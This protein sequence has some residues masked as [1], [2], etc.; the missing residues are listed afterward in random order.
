MSLAFKRWD[1][2]MDRKKK[3]RL[4]QIF[5]LVIGLGIVSITYL[6]KNGL[7]ESNIISSDLKNKIDNNAQNNTG[8]NAN[9]FYNVK[10]SGLDL[11][12]NR[13]TILSKEA[14][15]SDKLEN[16]V[17][18]KDVEASFY[19]KDNTILNIS[20]KMGEYNNKTLDMRF[21]K[22]VSALY[23]NSK[24]YAGKAEFLNSQNALIV[25]DN[26][27]IFDTKGTMF[28]DK[29]TFDIKNKTLNITSLKDNVVKSKLNY[30]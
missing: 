2:I 9:K 15:N 24:L 14:V 6:Q 29:L 20:S 13:Y 12:G 16:L 18:M 8:E 11:E 1:Q 10:Y 17:I 23:E 21:T 4:Y 27:K 28:A 19:F 26:V 22:N 5:I 25:S 3:L 7:N 30:K